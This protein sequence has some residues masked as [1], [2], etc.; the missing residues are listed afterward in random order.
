MMQEAMLV[1]IDI[2]RPEYTLS[3]DLGLH[4]YISNPTKPTA[5]L[6]VMT[7][8]IS[9]WRLL[10]A[11]FCEMANSVIGEGGKHLEYKQLIFNPKT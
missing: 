6:T 8:Q 10:M 11:W 4:N 3:E 1:C 2:Y 9:M 7:Q 5:K